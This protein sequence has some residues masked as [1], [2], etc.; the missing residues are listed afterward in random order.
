[1]I[2]IISVPPLMAE[3]LRAEALEWESWAEASAEQAGLVERA[4][5]A[6]GAGP[7]RLESAGLAC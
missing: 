5:P 2:Y 3:A 1:M 6:V 7:A 4:A